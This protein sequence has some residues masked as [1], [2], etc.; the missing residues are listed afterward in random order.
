MIDIK[1]LRLAAVLLLVGLVL[2]VGIT[3]IHPGHEDANDHPAA[4]DEYSASAQWAAIHLGEF[5]GM[6]VIILGVVVLIFAFNTRQR[7]LE[8][9]GR[10][11]AISAAAALALYGALQAVDGVAL[12]RAVDAWASAPQ[13]E[14][15]ARFASAE[16]I[17]GLEEGMRSY[18]DVMLGL[19]LIL[20]AI[21]VIGVATNLRPI[22]Y[23]MGLS[24]FAQLAQGWILSIE[25][26][27]PT[28]T[29]TIIVSEILIALWVIWL[30]ITAGR[31]KE[32]VSAVSN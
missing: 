15:A 23:V 4:F 13:A 16:A 24:G 25:G 28:H 7:I 27:S 22:G 2:F 14:K 8:I 6:T 12:K 17:R 29:T 5:T 32:P 21:M 18:Q 9:M 20:L 26:F 1:S 11:A 10:L 31:L 3:A 19:A 30:L